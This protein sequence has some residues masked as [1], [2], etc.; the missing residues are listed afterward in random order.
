MTHPNLSYPFLC[1][2]KAYLELITLHCNYLYVCLPTNS[3]LHEGRLASCFCISSTSGET[4][5]FDHSIKD[6]SLKETI[7]CSTIFQNSR[8]EEGAP[9][10]F[11]S[12]V[13]KLREKPKGNCYSFLQK[14]NKKKPHQPGILARISSLTP[15]Y[16]P[17]G[18]S[19]SG[20]STFSIFFLLFTSMN[21]PFLSSRHKHT[22]TI[23]SIFIP[24]VYTLPSPRIPFPYYFKFYFSLKAW[25]KTTNSM[26]LSGTMPKQRK[27]SPFGISNTFPYVFYNQKF[28][29][30]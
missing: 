17:K 27:I 8:L 10:N 9:L 14:T 11:G 22:H 1:N 20:S 23:H 13:W 30:I 28:I 2:S 7:K 21:L 5:K 3:E 19:S 29:F 12:T 16:D 26:K 25:F 24:F 18:P 15:D 4:E 6:M